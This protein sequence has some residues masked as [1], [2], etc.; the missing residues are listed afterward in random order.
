MEE[1]SGRIRRTFFR[2][3]REGRNDA[4]GSFRI[5]VCG[6]GPQTGASFLAVSAALYLAE[7]G[8]RVTFFEG[9]D[10]DAGAA[11][12]YDSAGFDRRFTGRVFRDFYLEAAGGSRRGGPENMECGVRWILST[13]EFRESG[14]RLGESQRAGLFSR[15]QG[16]F[17]V[18]DF[19]ARKEGPWRGYLSETDLVIA[20]VDPMPSRLAAREE[21]FRFLKSLERRARISGAEA[22]GREERPG[23]LKEAKQGGA[24]GFFWIVNFMNAGVGKKEI[25]RFLGSRNV[26]FVPALEAV[27][28]YEDEYFCRFH[29]ENEEIRKAVLPALDAAFGIHLHKK[30]TSE[31]TS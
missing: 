9:W 1:R 14:A 24:P 30:F 20:V 19:S 10:P 27:W 4:P 21:E 17:T 11:S 3:Q 5:G 16:P 6:L 25:M 31:F 7:R 12:V 18:C 28:F 15:A 2:E 26:G 8:E 22:D 23:R 29:Y 13:P